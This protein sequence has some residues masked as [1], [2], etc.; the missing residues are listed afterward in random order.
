MNRTLYAH[1]LDPEYLGWRAESVF[2]LQR[3]QEKIESLLK[4]HAV[5]GNRVLLSDVQLT[6]SRAI[7][8]LF[9]DISFRRFLEAFPDFLSLRSP[10]ANAFKAVKSANLAA[11]LSGLGKAHGDH[12]VSSTFRDAKIVKSISEKFKS[13]SYEQDAAAICKACLRDEKDPFLRGLLY[14]VH[15]FCA[16]PQ[17]VTPCS[18]SGSSFDVVLHEAEAL[19]SREGISP[20]KV[21]AA[22]RYINDHAKPGQLHK[23]TPAVLAL[24]EAGLQDPANRVVYFNIIQAWNIGVSNTLRAD[25]DEAPAFEIVDPLPLLFG[26]FREATL[27]TNVTVAD[28]ELLETVLTSRWHP[29]QL[30]W[31]LIRRIRGNEKCRASISEYQ[32]KLTTAET[33]GKEFVSLNRSDSCSVNRGA[34]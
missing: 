24:H 27:E 23:R 13:S 29:S 7:L 9:N 22:L 31:E 6:D 15:H 10:P 12:W 8:S 26:Q 19:L 14:G 21:Q 18:E 34:A 1:W 17:Q 20:N 11:I 2:Y 3:R 25:R 16:F 32:Y 4:M 28:Q 33:V 30:T 5:L